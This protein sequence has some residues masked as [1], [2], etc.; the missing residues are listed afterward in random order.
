MLHFIAQGPTETL[1]N[2]S[3]PDTPMVL[4]AKAGIRGLGSS[5]SFTKLLTARMAMSG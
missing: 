4:T 3:H 1:C 5:Q 2:L